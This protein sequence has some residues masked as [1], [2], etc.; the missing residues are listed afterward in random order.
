VPD[1]S[2]LP[3]EVLAIAA[4]AICCA[5]PAVA[6]V[7]AG[8]IASGWGAALRLWPVSVAGLLL[9]GLGSVALLRRTRGRTNKPLD[10]NEASR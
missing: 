10:Q 3:A 2:R 7:V 1:R 9:L 5:L 6:I 4:V 8:V